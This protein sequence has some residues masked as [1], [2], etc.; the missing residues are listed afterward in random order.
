MLWQIVVAAVRLTAGDE[1]PSVEKKLLQGALGNGGGIPRVGLCFALALERNCSARTASPEVKSRVARRASYSV[2]D[3]RFMPLK[4]DTS[5][6]CEEAWLSATIMTLRF[7]HSCT[8][9]ST[10]ACGRQP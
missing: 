10:S 9:W 8:T 5:P 4:R 3:R 2:G 1:H 6:S 7:A